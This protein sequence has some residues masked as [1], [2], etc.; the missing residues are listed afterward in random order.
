M[1]PA[2][3]PD[4]LAEVSDV[5]NIA[6][7]EEVTHITLTQLKQ[8]L[9]AI[10][11]AP[12]RCAPAT[13]AGSDAG[14]ALAEGDADV[15]IAGG[16]ED[17]GLE[18]LGVWP[19]SAAIAPS[20]AVAA[21]PAPA[22]ASS[23]AADAAA[24]TL[25]PIGAYLRSIYPARALEKGLVKEDAERFEE[26]Y[27]ESSDDLFAEYREVEKENKNFILHLQEKYGISKLAFKIAQNLQ[28]RFDALSAKMGNKT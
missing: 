25:P 10:K 8:M 16:E 3:K 14:V 11:A 27:I 5:A 6:D 4:N 12:S 15:T 26:F 13:P 21:E 20:P 22:V 1:R 7:D 23:A 18:K 28:A 9:A 2:I 19:S 17:V 24:S